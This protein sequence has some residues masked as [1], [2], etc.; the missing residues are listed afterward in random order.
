MRGKF[1]ALEV[2]VALACLGWA[3]A[4]AW[5]MFGAGHAPPAQLWGPVIL[6]PVAAWLL[7]RALWRRWRGRGEG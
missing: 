7:G 5:S 2:A 6:G 1:P 3:H 4:V